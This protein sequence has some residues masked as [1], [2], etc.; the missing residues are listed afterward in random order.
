MTDKV[1]SRIVAACEG[2][3]HQLRLHIPRIPDAVIVI[4]TATPITGSTWSGDRPADTW[5][6]DGETL[7]EVAIAAAALSSHND[8][9]K[10]NA[11][12][13]FALLV[14]E[15]THAINA[16]DG[17]QD[18]SRQGRYHNRVFHGT[19]RS[20]FGVLRNSERTSRPSLDDVFFWLRGERWDYNQQAA[21]DNAL[22]TLVD[23][24]ASE[25]IRVPQSRRETAQT[26]YI[27]LM[28]SCGQLIRCAP[29]T[30]RRHQILCT[31]CSY[32]F[33]HEST[34]RTQIALGGAIAY[35]DLSA[36]IATL[37]EQINSQASAHDALAARYHVLE[38]EHATAT[39]TATETTAPVATPDPP[40]RRELEFFV[41][42]DSS[43]LLADLLEEDCTF[44]DESTLST[45][46]DLRPQII[47]HAL[48]FASSASSDDLRKLYRAAKQLTAL[49]TDDDD[50]DPSTSPSGPQRRAL[51]FSDDTA[52]TERNPNA[53][54]N[55]S[56]AAAPE[57]TAPDLEAE[58]GAALET[59]GTQN[60]AIVAALRECATHISALFSDG[61]T[62]HRYRLT[63]GWTMPGGAFAGA[64]TANAT[65][66]AFSRGTQTRLNR[67]Q[68]RW[69]LEKCTATFDFS[70]DDSFDD[71]LGD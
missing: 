64:D 28:C 49:E 17:N 31:G 22:S 48:A 67:Q 53:A 12:H 18:T 56:L 26:G 58:L 16:V 45:D 57:P 62:W 35:A 71:I 46:T 3:W 4:N 30:Y 41:A 44:A 13:V 43:R 34:P 27:P 21:L 70:M 2:V 29:S 8:D 5:T 10:D 68:A 52:P 59:D 14:H 69:I 66:H 60:A 25:R 6:N 40:A 38:G 15:A 23:A 61:D 63:D 32:T 24:L 7:G 51:E 19:A 11:Y 9:T 33:E 37:R 20:C 1:G 42:A 36:T 47:A 54:A 50:D 39:A 65:A 55:A